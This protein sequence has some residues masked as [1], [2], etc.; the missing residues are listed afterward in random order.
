M[1]EWL[2]YMTLAL[3]VSVLIFLIIA[4]TEFNQTL[5]QPSNYL[6]LLSVGVVLL[7]YIFSLG[8]YFWNP[9]KPIDLNIKIPGFLKSLNIKTL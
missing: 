1:H 7:L 2:Y 5:P 8:L 9:G 4:Y 6:V 3:V